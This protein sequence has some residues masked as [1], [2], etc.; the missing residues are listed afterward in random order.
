MKERKNVDDLRTGR[1]P[2]R[3]LLLRRGIV[4]VGEDIYAHDLLVDPLASLGFLRAA[5]FMKR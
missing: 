2:A 5:V 4:V 3:V 1:T